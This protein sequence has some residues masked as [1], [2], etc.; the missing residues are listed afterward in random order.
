LV[1]EF[2]CGLWKMVA[3]AAVV[4]MASRLRPDW[5]SALIGCRA[6]PLTTRSPPDI[7]AGAD[8]LLHAHLD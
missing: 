4:A 1:E 6:H 5:N 8:S 7:V 3:T 2:Q